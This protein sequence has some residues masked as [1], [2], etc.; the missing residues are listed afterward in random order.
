M[1]RTN[2]IRVTLLLICILVLGC[3]LWLRHMQGETRQHVTQ[4]LASYGLP[5]LPLTA[6]SVRLGRDC[7]LMHC[8]TVAE[9][10]DGAGRVL[11]W[12][13]DARRRVHAA[14]GLERPGEKWYYFTA[15]G[16]ETVMW[17]ADPLRGSVKI[18]VNAG[19]PGVL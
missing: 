18:V 19:D 15:P 13:D 7:D 9:F 5:E 10:S 17:T 12:N 14:A 3:V 8:E 2:R 6:G 1:T 4:L 11:A 16:G